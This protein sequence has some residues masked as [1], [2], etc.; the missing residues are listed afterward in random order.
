MNL[1]S[2]R[3]V[4]DVTIYIVDVYLHFY[5]GTLFMNPGFAFIIIFDGTMNTKFSGPISFGFSF[6]FYFIFAYI[7]LDQLDYEAMPCAAWFYPTRN[8]CLPS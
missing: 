5:I 1:S 6:A 8:S 4:Q 7:L 2:C 3:Q